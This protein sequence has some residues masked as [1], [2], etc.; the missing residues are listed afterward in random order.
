M[1]SIKFNVSLLVY[2][3]KSHNSSLCIEVTIASFFESLCTE[4]EHCYTTLLTEHSSFFNASLSV[5]GESS[6]QQ[7][8]L[9]ISLQE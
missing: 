8:F 2:N 5:P 6:Y 4:I 1:L 3:R 9:K 7:N